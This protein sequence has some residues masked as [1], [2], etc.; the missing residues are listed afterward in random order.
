MKN[1]QNGVRAIDRSVN[2]A[3]SDLQNLFAFVAKKRANVWLTTAAVLFVLGFAIV[4]VTIGNDLSYQSEAAF[5][6]G[7]ANTPPPTEQVDPNLPANEDPLPSDQDGTQTQNTNTTINTTTNT[8]P[9]KPIT[10][11][12]KECAGSGQRTVTGGAFR[13]SG[14]STIEVGKVACFTIQT[15][16]SGSSQSLISVGIDWKDATIQSGL[17][18]G[19]IKHNYLNTGSYNIDF[20]VSQNIALSVDGGSGDDFYADSNSS[21][22]V[23]P[24][25]INF[26]ITVT[27]GPTAVITATLEGLTQETGSIAQ[28]SRPQ[29]AYIKLTNTSNQPAIIYA[30][31]PGCIDPFNSGK[32]VYK[33]SFFGKTYRVSSDSASSIL[34]GGNIISSGREIGFGD[35]RLRMLCN[36]AIGKLNGKSNLYTGGNNAQPI[37]I[38][39][40]GTYKIR[41]FADISR[42]DPGV[43]LRA[44][45]LTI[46]GKVGNATGVIYN[47]QPLM[48]PCRTVAGVRNA[49]T[50]PYVPPG[51]SASNSQ[52]TTNR[53]S[54]S[55]TQKT[56]SGQTT[57]TKTQTTTTTKKINPITD[58][59]K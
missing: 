32:T 9:T 16:S 1:S 4:F 35:P 47:G 53:E 22:P 49:A 54:T 38:A 37:T 11:D 57:K 59:V 44:G 40:G 3:Q 56:E 12:T 39:A 25:L 7:R 13:I 19:Q 17:A 46:L 30:I 20:S 34:T 8:D 31:I 14:P 23:E 51:C 50:V 27:A 26:P 58:T 28:G 33:G 10:S 36:A 2:R 6:R 29:F 41:V 52:Q 5:L 45:L 43:I 15:G 48:G 55:A 18:V 21:G 24:A 42:P